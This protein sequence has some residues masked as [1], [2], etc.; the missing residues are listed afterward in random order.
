L[1]ASSSRR[2]WPRVSAP[3]ELDRLLEA[4]QA[5]QRMPSVSAAAFRHDDVLWQRAI[6][7]ADVERGEAATSDHVYRVGSITKTFTAVL[8]LQLREEGALRLDDELRQH[9]GEVPPGP[10][11]RHALSHL[12]GL[13]REPPGEIWETL[14]PPSR[15]ELLAGLAD[16]EQVLSPGERWHY[17]NLAYGLLGELVARLRGASYRDV[18]Q[19]RVLDP[20]ELSR[21]GLVPTAPAATGYL[22]DPWSDAASVEAD[23]EMTDVTAALGQLWSTT[24]DLARFGAFVARGDD[25]VLTRSALDEMARVAVIAD[26]DRWTVAWGLGLGLY[27]GG[28]RIYAGHGGAMPGF[29]ASLIVSREEATGAVVLTNSGAGPKVE[30]LALELAEAAHR[31]TAPPVPEWRP[32]DGAPADVVAMLGAWWTEGSELRITWRDGRLRAEVLSGAP[33]NRDS[34]FE[35]EGDDRW[36]CVEGRE[37]GE[38]LRV[39]R[40]E[41]GAPVKLYFAT[42]PCTREP[43]T[44]GA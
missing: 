23:V 1:P 2:P 9:V 28:D 42:Y 8:V 20:L 34:T 37:R 36:R 22:V 17:S 13:Q 24:G 43:A 35:P 40:D 19:E 25:R 15:E 6:G 5:E 3:D 7:L 12:S 30:T 16:A 44:F 10:T 14:Q 41:A 32:D 27:R 26:E 31:L 39:V 38:L 33:W 29:L 4:A 21:T 18:L 11:V